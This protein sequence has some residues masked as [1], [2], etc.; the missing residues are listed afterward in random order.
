MP[1]VTVMTTAGANIVGSVVGVFNS[2]G[3]PILGATPY[4][5]AATDG[6]VSVYDDRDALY[7]VQV[8]SAGVPLTAAA[9]WDQADATFD[10]GN[11]TG[12]SAHMLSETLK[13][14]TGQGMFRIE[15]LAQ[16]PGNVWAAN[17]KV[18]V[19]LAEH[20]RQAARAAI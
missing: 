9:C 2:N 8:K 10:A 11:S 15:R 16:D 13:G 6:Y 20:I 1:A 17:C 18:V 12:N 5:A 3:A 7:T 4:L 19:S 14:G